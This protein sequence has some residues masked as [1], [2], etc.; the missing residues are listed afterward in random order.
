ML[1]LVVKQMEDYTV[2]RVM[3]F[4]YSKNKYE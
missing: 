3:S 1:L 2:K 4:V